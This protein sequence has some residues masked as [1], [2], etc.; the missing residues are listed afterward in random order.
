MSIGK[1]N[2]LR[3]MMINMMYLVLTALLALNVSAEILNAF[4]TVNAGMTKS[5]ELMNTTQEATMKNLDKL[6][7]Q[8]KSSTQPFYDLAQQTNKIA[9]DYYKKIEA[10]IEQVAEETGGWAEEGEGHGAVEGVK[11]LK[12]MADLEVASRLFAEEESQYGKSF[13]ADI[14]KMRDE[15][16][17][18]AKELSKLNTRFDVDN[19]MPN[20][21]VEAKNVDNGKSW[22]YNNFHMVPSIAVV[23]VL[24]KMQQDI[25]TTQG[26]LI[27]A[28]VNS[29][30]ADE[31]SFDQ[32]V[33]VVRP[34]T[35]TSLSVGE[36][37]EADVLLAAY[38]SKQAPEI[39]I[40]GELQPVENGMAHYVGSTG[41]QG[42]F[43]R[44]GKI[45]V[46]N[47]KTGEKKEYPFMIAYDVFNAPA[48]I[49]PTKMNVLYAGLKN[50]ISVSVPGY[51]ASD[52]KPYFPSGS[53]GNPKLT[54]D[55]GAGNY[56]AQVKEIRGKN[57][58]VK[59]YVNVT[60]SD[61]STKKAGEQV[62]RVMK[63]PAPEAYFGP[64]A[65]GQTITRTELKLASFVSARLE[66]FVFE[67]IRYKVSEYNFLFYPKR[68]EVMS[69]K[70]RGSR[71]PS[72]IKSALNGA[73][74]GD[75]IIITGIRASAP[76]LGKVALKP[77]V[78]DVI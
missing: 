43:E 27:N 49:S 73:R 8:A 53:K 18:V 65:S 42:S 35:K 72:D 1:A 4:S 26:N 64:K 57:R 28:I 3:Q 31:T 70:V 38:D 46:T 78:L 19:F 41:A 59:M 52:I 30:G 56:I 76:G 68:G 29:I 21:T 48:V 39:Y 66:N 6:L 58:T 45:V 63:V 25:R 36:P 75:Q 9:E 17:N 22:A 13:E 55:K 60:N 10:I 33:A 5:I 61:G 34:N 74:K 77:I 54:P 32:L 14:N 11:Q 2:P 7:N 51:K 16:I 47:K 15:F 24:T 67:G 37:F 20:I 69:K 71:V 50:P 23:T 62:F 44:E 12:N 40:D